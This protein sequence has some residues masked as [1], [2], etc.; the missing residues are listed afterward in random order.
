MG[1]RDSLRW[2]MDGPDSSYSC[3]VHQ[4]FWKVLSD[5]KMDP[6]IQTLYFLSGGAMTLTWHRLCFRITEN[7]ATERGI[8]FI[9]AGARAVSSLVMRSAIPGNIVVPPDMTIFP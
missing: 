1:P 3:L 9:L 8:T 4:R 5:A 2:T 7:G 6:P